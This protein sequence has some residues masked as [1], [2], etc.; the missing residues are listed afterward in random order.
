MKLGDAARGDDEQRLLC[1]ITQSMTSNQAIP[2][3]EVTGLIPSYT[4][5]CL[6][7]ASLENV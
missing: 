2:C 6:L 1:G 5:E 7:H 3:E 4:E